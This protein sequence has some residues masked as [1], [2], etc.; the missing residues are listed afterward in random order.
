VKYL[1]WGDLQMHPWQETQRPDRWRNM[2]GV[3]SDVFTQAHKHSVDCIVCLGDLFESK[4]AVRADVMSETMD[5]LIGHHRKHNFLSIYISGNHDFYG[6]ESSLTPL[7][8]LQN[9][10]VVA[11]YPLYIPGSEASLCI[12]FGCKNFES[13]KEDYRIL[14]THNDIVGARVNKHVLTKE[15]GI[16]DRFLKRKRVRKAV[17]NGHY[18]HPQ[19][20]IISEDHVPVTCVGSPVQINWSDADSKRERGFLLI[21]ETPSAVK[22]SRIYL[23]KYPKFY[24]GNPPEAREGIDFVREVVDRKTSTS[25]NSN[26][27]GGTKIGTALTEYTKSVYNGDLDIQEVID[28][29]KD[30]L[31]LNTIKE[32]V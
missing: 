25:S 8:N 6:G 30:L 14:F 16:P 24:N 11:D 3:V 1:V 21:N 22:L 27:I 12:P 23:P 20:I 7:G 29:G 10:H 19:K 2:L 18:H 13:S 31:N 9:V 32:D 15:S 4:S 26:K 28:I 17:I 5:C